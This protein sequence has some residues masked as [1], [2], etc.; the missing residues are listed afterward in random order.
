MALT[1]EADD[2]RAVVRAH[3]VVARRAVE[4]R[5]GS[6]LVDVVLT[7]G[8]LVAGRTGQAGRRAGRHVRLQADGSVLTRRA[9][10]ATR[11]VERALAAAGCRHTSLVPRRPPDAT[12]GRNMPCSGSNGGGS[13]GSEDPPKLLEGGFIIFASRAFRATDTDVDSK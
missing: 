2:A 4:T 12:H 11:A 7:D 8:A 1:F 3:Q 6:A 9:G 5:R 10:A 13:Q